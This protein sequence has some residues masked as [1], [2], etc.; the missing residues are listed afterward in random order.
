METD[1]SSLRS[2]L[3]LPKPQKTQ[4]KIQYILIASTELLTTLRD[5]KQELQ[6]VLSDK[7]LKD[8]FCILNHIAD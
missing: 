6:I 7:F 1:A 3:I 8:C 5:C 4:F 2:D